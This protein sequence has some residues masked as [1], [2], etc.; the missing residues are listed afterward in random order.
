MK[1]KW[2]LTFIDMFAGPGRCLIEIQNIEEEGS[3]LKALQ[4]DFSKYIFVEESP[5][6]IEALRTRCKSSPKLLQIDFIPGDCNKFIDQILQKIP[7]SSLGLAFIDPTDIEI[8]FETI[9]KLAAHQHG[10]DLL[11]IIQFGMDIKRNFRLYR[12]QGDMSKL[13]LFLGSNVD[14]NK[15]K[16]P[17]DA[18]EL[19]KENIGRLGYST[20]RF[21]DIEVRNRK[22]VP[23]YFLLFASK[24]PR[25]LDFWE[26]ITRKDES[27]QMEFI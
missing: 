10:I 21:K 14:W 2:Q 23:L 8:H 11:M 7:K 25:G 4:Y 22:N 19:Y 16:D 26:K 5:L 18:I 9:G 12:E 20:V 6:D 3:P 13:G 27:G 24:H 15:M 1:K 17:R